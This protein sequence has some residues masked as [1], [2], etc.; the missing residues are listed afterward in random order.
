MI[1]RLFFVTALMVLFSGIVLAQE[2]KAA[3][4]TEAAADSIMIADFEG[5]PNNLGGEMGVYGSLEPDWDE[6]QTSPYS[7]VYEIITPGYNPEHIY[8]G[9]QSFRLVNALGMKPDEAWGS[10]AMDLGPTTDLTVTPKRVESFDASAYKYLIFWLKGE[11]GGEKLSFL[12]RDAHALGY[13]PQVKHSLADA[14]T[15]WQKIVIPL[16]QFKSKVDIGALDNIG[17]AFGRDVGNLKGEIV[18]IDSFMFTNSK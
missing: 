4:V 2:E 3:E 5:W 10:F 6:M 7:W 15:E 12:M 14:T 17:L 18:Y 16:D 13:M 1:K 11:K 9:R 8:D